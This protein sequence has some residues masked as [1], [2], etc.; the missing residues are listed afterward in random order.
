LRSAGLTSWQ[1]S[2][3][4]E[5]YGSGVFATTQSP[6]NYANLVNHA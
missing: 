2:Q 5:A 3:R 1:A 6:V 4:P